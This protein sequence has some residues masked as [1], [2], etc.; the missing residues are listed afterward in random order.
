MSRFINT[1]L[2]SLQF[3]IELYLTKGWVT[4]YNYD[5]HKKIYIQRLNEIQAF[6]NLILKFLSYG[7]GSLH[8][9]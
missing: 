6:I 5:S 4:Q 1:K 2:T 3:Q 7:K 9:N 8:E